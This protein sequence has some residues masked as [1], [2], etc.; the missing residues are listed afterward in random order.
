[1][2]VIMATTT[3]T[4]IFFI[5]IIV[6]KAHTVQS[7]SAA[8]LQQNIE[9]TKKKQNMRIYLWGQKIIRTFVAILK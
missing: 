2:A 1:M 9:T 5:T 8:K 7:Y 3:I 4:K 6:S